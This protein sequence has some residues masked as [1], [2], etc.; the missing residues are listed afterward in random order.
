M[1]RSKEAGSMNKY[2]QCH[3]SPALLSQQIREVRSSVWRLVACISLIC[4]VFGF[5][6]N[7]PSTK[8]HLRKLNT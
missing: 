2:E 4:G 6:H 1:S 3:F 8:C 7:P 5:A